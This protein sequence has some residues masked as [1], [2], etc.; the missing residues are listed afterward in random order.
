[1]GSALIREMQ[2]AGVA[3]CAKHYPGHGDTSKD[4]H[5]ELPSVAHDM[6]RLEEVHPPPSPL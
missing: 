6:A 2:R 4:S 3:A 1:M 5:L